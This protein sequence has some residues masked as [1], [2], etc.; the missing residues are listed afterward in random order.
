MLV[1]GTTH[2][3]VATIQRFCFSLKTG[4]PSPRQN[5]TT[6]MRLNVSART[7]NRQHM[8]VIGQ[9]PDKARIL[10][11]KKV[12]A[13]A[14][15]SVVRPSSKVSTYFD[16][17]GEKTRE[18]DQQHDRVGWI[19]YIRSLAIEGYGNQIHLVGGQGVECKRRAR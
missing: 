17:H 6:R 11:A 2:E 1:A 3:A 14:S 15:G 7:F 19:E 16:E 12:C 13:R 8:T 18:Q 9:R 4:N 5:T 10:N